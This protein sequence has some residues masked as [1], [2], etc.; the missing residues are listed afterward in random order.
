M[1]WLVPL[2]NKVNVVAKA[3]MRRSDIPPFDS[4]D[5]F[6]SGKVRDREVGRAILK[7]AK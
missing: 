1:D 4:Q 3:E 2:I 5:E 7:I 6:V